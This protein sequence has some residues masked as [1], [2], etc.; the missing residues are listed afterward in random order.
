MSVRP[1][2][3]AIQCTVCGESLGRADFV[4]LRQDS[5]FIG[6]ENGK[7]WQQDPKPW[8]PGVTLHPHCVQP[9]FDALIDDT[10]HTLNEVIAELG[11][12]DDDPEAWQS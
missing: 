3:Q 2:I 8:L 7:Y 12:D 4:S 1:S 10:R 6:F 9:F 11:G 5:I